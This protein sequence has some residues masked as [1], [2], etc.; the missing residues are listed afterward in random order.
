M[1]NKRNQFAKRKE[2]VVS[3][4]STLKEI[5]QRKTSTRKPKFNTKRNVYEDG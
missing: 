1:L 5:Q 3:L 4:N 2:V